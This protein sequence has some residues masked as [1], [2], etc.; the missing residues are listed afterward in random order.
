MTT[1][2]SSLD[3]RL[4]QALCEHPREHD[5]RYDA[6]A[7]NSLLEF[8][9]RALTNDRTDYLGELFPQGFPP[10]YKLQDAQGVQ[11]NAEYSAAAR[12]HPCGHIF[13]PGEASYHCSTCTDDTTAVLCSRCFIASDHDGHQ[14]SVN[15]SAGNSGC[16]DCGDDEA[17]KRPVKCAI[18]T[19][20]DDWATTDE[21]VS[22]LP[23]DLQDSIRTTIA[24]VL[25]Y[26]CDIIS[27]SPEN[28]RLPKTVE[29]VTQ[30]EVRSRLSAEHY[31]PGDEVETNPDYCL[32]IWNDEKHTVREV[33]SQVARAC[34]QREA[35]GLA[36]AEEANDVG[37]SVIRHSRDL[38]E[39]T[40]MA[41]IIEEIKVTVTIRSSRDTFREQMCGT[42][43]EWLADIAASS[44][45]GD[46]HILRR[47]ICEEMLQIWRIGSEAWNAKVGREDLDDHG[48]EDDREYR[49]R[50]RL[51]FF[52][53]IQFAM[54]RAV[55]GEIL[56]DE[57]EGSDGDETGD[58]DDDE[59]DEDE[60]DNELVDVDD[61]EMND[62]L[63]AATVFDAPH[64]LNLLA[65]QAGDADVTDDA[66]EMDTDGDGDFL[67]IAERMDMDGPS[68]TPPALP[69]Q[70]IGD[71]GNNV[72]MGEG[73]SPTDPDSNANYLNI[74][75]TPAA[76]ARRT[77]HRP[78]PPNHWKL[79]P[80]SQPP[81]N[82]TIPVY[83]DLTK[84]IR[85]DSMILFD[86][87]LWKLARTNMR[88]LF[89]STL[90]NIPQFKR[91]LGLRFSGLY[92]T[93]A[94]LYLV[95]DREPDHSIINLSL[96]LL[97]TPSITE[98]VIGR[99]NFLTNLMAILYTFLTTRQVGFPKDL[100]PGATLGFDA[101]SV[102]NRRLYHFFSDLRYFLA[103]PFVQ[104]KA[105]SEPQYLS[106]F[107][108]LAKL[109]QGICPNVRAV[110]E[111]VE[112]ETDAW[113]SA[114]LLTRDINKLCR[115]F[116]EAYYVSKVSSSSALRSTWDAISHAA[117]VAIIN[118]VGLER[119]RFEQA[120]IK[121]PVRF[122]TVAP[123]GYKVVDFVV[124]K[125]ALSFH[126]PLHYTLSWLLECGKEF[127][128]SIHTLRETAQTFLS[129]LHDTH[130]GSRDSAIK[131]TL[132]SADDALL[133]MFDYPLRVCAWLAQM[134]ANLWV[135]N[136]MS[137][138]HQMV[139]YK[140]V[141]HRDVGHHRD[142]FLLQTAL[143]ACDPSRVL[144][145]MIDRFGL[146]AWM[147]N[148]FDSLEICD[149]NQMLDLAED[150]VYL[151]INLLS[152]RD[153]LISDR[154]N[155]ETQ[156]L[157]LRKDI[158][159]TLCFKPL[160]YSDLYSRLTERAQDHEQL[161]EVLDQMTRYRPPEGLHDSGLFELKEEYLQELDPYNSHFTKNQRDEAENIY[162]SWMGK[163]LHKPPEDIVLDPKLHP[164]PCEAYASLCAVVNTTIFADVIHK[165][166]VYV[167][168]GHKSKAGVSATRVEAFLQIVLQLALIATL[169]DNSSDD[170]GDGPSFI[171]HAMKLELESY[172]SPPSTIIAVLSKI[173][174]MEEFSSC[175][176]KIRHMLRLF[177]Q[178]LP[179]QFTTATR[180]L[181]F[182]SGRFD[183]ASPAN[184][185]S[186]IEAKKK[187]AMERKARVMAQ[188]QQQ[189]QSFMDKQ[190]MTDWGDE[191]LDSPDEELP[192]STEMR[193]WKYPAG[194][195]IQCREDTS[196]SRF[197]GTFAMITD[198]H[199]LRET[200]T[201][202]V[203]F[204]GELFAIPDNLDRSL[205][206]IR[207]F[208]VSGS[209]HEQVKRLTAD[210]QE[211][212]VDFQSLGKGWPQG[213]TMK[214]PVSTSCGHI[215]HFTCFE[216]YYQSITRRHSQQVARNHPERISLKE[217]VCPLCKALANTFLPIVWKH[218]QQSY[219]G[220]LQVSQE[221]DS[222][223]DKNLPSTDAPTAAQDPSF[224][225]HA[226]QTYLQTLATFSNSSLAPAIARWQ[227]GDLTISPTS[228]AWAERP[229]L[230]AFAE[231]ASIYGRLRETLAIVAATSRVAA[232]QEDS[233]L[234]HFHL[235]VDTLANTICSVE[236]GHRGREAE[237][238]TSLLTS[239][240]QQTLSHLQTLSSTLNAYAAT[241]ALTVRGSV[242]AQYRELCDRL[243][244]QLAGI[245]S[246]MTPSTESETAVPLLCM[247][248]FQFLV[249]ATMVLSPIRSLELRHVLQ[250]ALTLELLRVVLAFLLKPTAL[251][252]VGEMLTQNHIRQASL[253][254]S[255]T[256]QRRSLEDIVLWIRQQIQQTDEGRHFPNDLSPTTTGMLFKLCKVYALAFLR[257]SAV[258][259]HVAHGVDFPTTAGSEAGLPEL[260]RLCHLLHVPNID[261][262]L[263]SFSEYST[264]G[265][266]KY[267][268]GIWLQ[269]C[270]RF[271]MMKKGM[272]QLVGV[273]VR[274]MG[275]KLL[276]PAPFELIG[277]PKYF[278]VLMEESHRQKCPTTG[279]EVLDP[280]LCLFCGEIF[281][282][283]TVCCQ[284][285]DKRGG[286]NAHIE[287]CS[288]P[289]GMFLFIRKCHVALLH[290]T[291]DPKVGNQD[292]LRRIHGLPPS[293][294]MS[295]GS[296]FPAPYL[297]KHGET[298][299]G[300]RS[301]H[302]LI[303][304]Q[305]RYDKLLR[306][307]WLMING[308][309]WSTIA[310]KL[311]SEVNAGGWETL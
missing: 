83:E 59:D 58:V 226:S 6:S 170:A 230:A 249:Q 44:I 128:Q 84:N 300:L 146:S 15:V 154:D 2:T 281:C 191:D 224:D 116:A 147:R 250:M 252:K 225:A 178:V 60:D 150:F 166:L 69:P 236:I 220:T 121:E 186:E 28:L 132:N 246:N 21:H 51:R 184:I 36:K 200:A 160:S 135:R 10:S 96:Q 47:V 148:G 294:T 89:I 33:Q 203:D 165:A 164:I 37:R 79:A 68:P 274:L 238:G 308:S 114:S 145:S 175:R 283:Q 19:A 301:K 268:A 102:A 177:H 174:L 247:D 288:S 20:S 261:D 34:R 219:P 240:P 143:V 35:F 17:W 260:E 22:P 129:H 222:F 57:D 26:F 13:K 266:L 115:Q 104:A 206:N 211:V 311:E 214:G 257:K 151:L 207:P 41:K 182:P 242:E 38:K 213:Y 180:N 78:P 108:D 54:Q 48:E 24:T 256:E 42:I 16:C 194:L 63:L 56:D 87:R 5:Y 158:A 49:R 229:E 245:T 109:S 254:T 8:L 153:A 125:G 122:H 199:I 190:G 244:R 43:I 18:H 77:R 113:I 126:H 50:T 131:T 124:E 181:D 81:Q 30:D 276:H 259:F 298:D 70:D 215:M 273:P 307:T 45:A 106:Q 136:G 253:P 289:I 278:D 80:S 139:Q 192:K 217:F 232:P 291:K 14:Y 251:S 221:F 297:T 202:D 255:E 223:L 76:S 107:L 208:G 279:K 163:K 258:F 204:V 173:W 169:E 140:S 149:D 155:M 29:S 187:Q 161:Q 292:I 264:S 130:L 234:N 92:T 95:A 176:S 290:V 91:I 97:T 231:L 156:L 119:R 265:T 52:D 134:K 94:Q 11:E 189:Q 82:A 305:K 39:L 183:T 262:I 32:I 62:L 185:E 277:L 267:R 167:A 157:A 111:H 306:D 168:H 286:C 282:S 233:N 197:Y 210:G 72:A 271:E 118:S 86:L 162:K 248:P 117:G 133:A 303:L 304:N 263:R 137:L 4:R 99:G 299:S 120:E 101:G 110:G 93:L 188:F 138:R 74:P 103:S 309:V 105:R 179:H 218:S 141:A 127:K 302:Q 46:G 239:M 3:R 280:A 9:F 295:H 241:G 171:R 27:C 209:N 172:D 65:E 235:L 293:S 275:I 53:P 7:K 198:A 310:R 90:V 12:G 243:E 25:D 85:V 123:Y 159:H 287:K 227:S 55:A 196:D 228:Q 144:A 212:T 284:T 195:C 216:N 64:R 269:D 67:D 71:P 296:F 272:P 112:Y 201:D 1:P 100:D 285:K 270:I 73:A 193:H 40:R 98:E 142:L 75:R 205:E 237:F 66:E 61:R 152:D 23:A 31:V 88:D